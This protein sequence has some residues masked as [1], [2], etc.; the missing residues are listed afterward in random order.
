MKKIGLLA[1]SVAVTLAGGWMLGTL[2]ISQTGNMPEWMNHA[3]RVLLHITGRE[4]FA[5]P[6]DLP[7]LG[8]LAI[9]IASIIICGLL[10]WI[11]NVAICRARTRRAQA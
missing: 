11:A 6:D 3:L 4:D 5:N 10:V 9:L 2:T 1:L 8:M 7:A